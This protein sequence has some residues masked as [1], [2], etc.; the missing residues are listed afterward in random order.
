MMDMTRAPQ[1]DIFNFLDLLTQRFDDAAFEIRALNA[2]YMHRQVVSGYYN[3]SSLDLA[4]EAAAS[5]NRK[6]GGV[7]VTLNPVDPALLGRANQR[8]IERPKETTADANILRRHWLP[9]DFDPRRPSG[10]S[11]TEM[12][13][14]AAIARADECQTWLR[15]QGWSDPLFGD[16]GN[17][18]HLLYPVDEPNT[19][20]TRTLFANV[21]KSLA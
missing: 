12:E 4:V 10:I 18:A 20:E 6:C 19:E 7:Y 15:T 11:S 13:H 8:L 5:L 2:G 21:L 1:A 3:R 17:G 16:S 14:A 9:V